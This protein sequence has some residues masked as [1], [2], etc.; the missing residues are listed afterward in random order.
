MAKRQ[1][2]RRQERRDQHARRQGW[3]TRHSV[4]TGAG[5]AAGAALG[6][7]SGAQAAATYYY[8]GSK[9]D[10]TGATD[11]ADNT[12]TDCTLRDAITA[13]NANPGADTIYFD[14]GITGTIAL[15]T[16]SGGQIP[17][18]EGV[19]IFG[20]GPDLV[21][22]QAAPSSRIFDVDPTTAGDRVVIDG[23]TLTG[24]DVTGDGGAIRNNDARLRLFEAVV[25][26]NTASGNGGA[27]YEPGNYSNGQYDYIS[28]STFSGNVAGAGGAIFAGVDWGYLRN[29]TFAGNFAVTGYGGAVDGSYGNLVDSTVSGNHAAQQGGGVGA[30]KNIGLFGTILANNTGSANP[31]LYSPSGGSASFDL[32]EN[33]GTTGIDVVP[34]VITGQDPQ[35]GALGMNGGYMPTLKPAAS[36]PVVDQSYSNSYYDER[37]FTRP[38]DNPNKAN[39]P[40]GNGADIG[41]VELT[42]AEG[43]QAGPPAPAPVTPVT[44]HKKKKC[45]KKKHKRSAESA[46]KKKC[47]KKKKR[48]FDSQHG[49]RFARPSA[50]VPRW[51]DAAEHHPFRLGR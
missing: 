15:T 48:S 22:V 5:L 37:F 2:R 25:S 19:Y 16:P 4:I 50:D 21:T 27:I 46:K 17:I 6:M 8:V 13:S 26:G 35:L 1:R 36:S 23:L 10:T 20:P 49:F 47:K 45:K 28:Y 42:L 24:G 11:C 33:P 30:D 51:P 41:A 7:A 34:S 12:N 40:G 38:V 32:V 9:L 3:R 14:S 44:P 31:D 39:A 18:T 43:P 29:D